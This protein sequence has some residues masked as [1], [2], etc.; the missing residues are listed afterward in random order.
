MPINQLPYKSFS[1]DFSKL[2][3]EI[4]EVSGV[5]AI[6]EKTTNRMYVGSSY[7]LFIRL[8][9]HSNKL[10]NN[11]HYN[12]H[13]QNS[14]NKYTKDNFYCIVLQFCS[15]ESLVDTEQY[16]INLY[17]PEFNKVK[18][19]TQIHKFT[20][21][22]EI[23]KKISLSKLGKKHSLERNLKKSLQNKGKNH[24][25][26]HCEKISKSLTGKKLSEAHVEKLKNIDRSYNYKKIRQLDLDNNVIHTF[27][28][29][30][31][32]S[33]ILQISY[34]TIRHVLKKH[35]KSFN[36]FKFEYL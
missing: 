36:N 17:E 18:N 27:N 28:S 2:T 11:T 13:L 5:Y 7:N 12:K 8:Q 33:E 15:F 9:T 30:K 21:P 6:I 10:K 31:E 32:A 3:N 35:M 34:S 19:V 16:Y 29:I 26:I 1:T 4:P 22:E 14:Y 20:L 23:R 25:L 24:S